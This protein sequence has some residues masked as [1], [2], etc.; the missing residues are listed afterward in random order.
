MRALLDVDLRLIRIFRAITESQGLA[1]A[2]LLLNLSQ[3]RI[4]ASLSELETR[5]GVRLCR[6]GRSGF[7]LTEAGRSV[8]DASHDLFEAVDRFCNKA[9][10][11]SERLRRAIKLGAVD[12]LVSHREIGLPQLLHELRRTAPA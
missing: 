7:A 12:A 4:S 11:V 8:Y 2:Q 6:R 1:G 3:S 9:G 10:T 5:L